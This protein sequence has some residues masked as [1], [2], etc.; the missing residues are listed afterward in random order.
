[1]VVD[2]NDLPGNPKLNTRYSII[3]TATITGE[4][5]RIVPATNL[6]S[7]TEYELELDIDMQPIT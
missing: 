2:A 6:E 5:R 7:E 1:M 4:L 3:G